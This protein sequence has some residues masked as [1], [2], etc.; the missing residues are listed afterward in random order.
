PG[1]VPSGE[2]T[3]RSLE[4]GAHM[5]QSNVRSQQARRLEGELVGAPG[6]NAPEDRYVAGGDRRAPAEMLA[7]DVYKVGIVGHRFG[8]C[9]AIH[10]VPGCLELA[11]DAL[12]GSSIGG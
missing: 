7:P 3:V 5:H 1:R 11:N 6:V 2:R 10:R 9:R 8:E 12:E 4:Y